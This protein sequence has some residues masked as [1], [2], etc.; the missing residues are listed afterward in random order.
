M[1]R[2]EFFK[3]LMRYILLMLVALVVFVLGNKVVSAAG[4]ST[5]PGKGICTGENDCE[6]Y[7][8]STP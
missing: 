5:C 7:L 4:C 3:K 6:N 2:I 8:N 1:S